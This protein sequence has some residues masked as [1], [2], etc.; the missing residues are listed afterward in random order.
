[1][2]LGGAGKIDDKGG[3]IVSD[4][5]DIEGTAVGQSDESLSGR[6]GVNAATDRGALTV[7]VGLYR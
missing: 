2:S 1:M 6:H 4:N 7:D 3:A 5:E